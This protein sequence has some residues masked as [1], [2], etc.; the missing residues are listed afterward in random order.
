M[1][2]VTVDKVIDLRFTPGIVE[3][4]ENRHIYKIWLSRAIKL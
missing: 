2:K 3:G 4:Y 1:K